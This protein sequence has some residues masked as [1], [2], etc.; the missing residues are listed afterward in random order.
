MSIDR[1]PS[2]AYYKKQVQLLIVCKI[3]QSNAENGESTFLKGWKSREGTSFRHGA[4][5]GLFI[6]L[7]AVL[8]R[9]KG[10]ASGSRSAERR[11]PGN[12]KAEF[13]NRMQYFGAET[14]VGRFAGVRYTH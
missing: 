4:R 14:G 7:E 10:S 9:G 3:L 12:K 8:T 6:R 1:I 5:E 2:F 13:R 11:N